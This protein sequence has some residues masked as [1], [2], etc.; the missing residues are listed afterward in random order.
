MTMPKPT[1][2]MKMVTKMMMRGDRLFGI[3]RW[4]FLSSYESEKPTHEE[5]RVGVYQFDWGKQIR[6]ADRLDLGQ[7]TNRIRTL[8]G[9]A[10]VPARDRAWFLTY[11]RARRPART[12]LLSTSPSLNGTH[13][14]WLPVRMKGRPP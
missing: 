8:Y 11:G 2:S 9:R 1:R 4:G 6:M 3:G 12:G 5:S 7:Q 10:S 14:I 13:A